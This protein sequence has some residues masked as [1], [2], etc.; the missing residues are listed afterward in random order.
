[1]YFLWVYWRHLVLAFHRNGPPIRSLPQYC[2][3]NCLP[4]VRLI[5]QQVQYRVCIKCSRRQY[6]VSYI[7]VLSNPNLI[8]YVFPFTTF[9][10][11]RYVIIFVID[12]RYSI[13]CMQYLSIIVIIPIAINFPVRFFWHNKLQKSGRANVFLITNNNTVYN[14]LNFLV[15]IATLT[16]LIN[17]KIL[18]TSDSEANIRKNCSAMSSKGVGLSSSPSSLYAVTD[19]NCEIVWLSIYFS[20]LL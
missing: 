15:P 9:I 10:G 5:S 1:M 17:L 2:Q 20:L 19:V 3:L 13:S 18:S 4:S 14:Y 11:F 6:T 7:M 16:I 12:S 8:W